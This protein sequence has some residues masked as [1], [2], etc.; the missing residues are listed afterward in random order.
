MGIQGSALRKKNAGDLDNV[1]FISEYNFESKL[2]SYFA[3]KISKNGQKFDISDYTHSE[4]EQLSK[5]IEINPSLYN[6]PARVGFNYPFKNKMITTKG[7][8]DIIPG[9]KSKLDILQNKYPDV[10]IETISVQIRGGAFD[11]KPIFKI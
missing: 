2:K 5:D 10:N 3:N 1:I 7:Y 11:L 8:D 9:M 4:L 6:N